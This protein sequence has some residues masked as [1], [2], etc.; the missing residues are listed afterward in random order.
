[1]RV[2]P[3]ATAGIQAASQRFEASAARTARALTPAGADVDLAKEAVEQIGAKTAFSANIS[4]IRTA[5]EMTGRLLD[6]L[7]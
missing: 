1:M 5:D 4:V 3:I 2:L 7:A 6:M